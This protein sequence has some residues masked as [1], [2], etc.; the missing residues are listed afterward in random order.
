MVLLIKT[1]RFKG[2]Y[3]NNVP[4]DVMLRSAC[5]HIIVVDVTAPDDVE[6]TNY[7]D[8][9]SGWYMLWKKWF[10]VVY[11][12]RWYM[13][14]KKWN[15]FTSPVKIPTQNDIQERLAFCSHY[16]NLEALKSNPHY[17]YI[18]PPVGHFSR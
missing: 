16:K 12:L 6:L 18:F 7:G 11:C 4:G 10:I 1:N 3:V 5:S 2:C 17:E 9:L 14:W 8:A 13:L 15:P